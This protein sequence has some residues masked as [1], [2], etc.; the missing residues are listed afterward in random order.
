MVAINKT[1]K[2]NKKNLEKIKHIKKYRSLKSNISRKKKG[3]LYFRQSLRNKSTIN[4]NYVY[5]TMKQILSK[6]NYIYTHRD[7]LNMDAKTYNTL[8]SIKYKL[9]EKIRKIM[10]MLLEFMDDLKDSV[11][12][13]D[14]LPK[15]SIF[16]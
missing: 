14:I 6:I 16:K 11:E 8:I 4:I 15:S 3:G 13:I 5:R 7:N 12:P 10:H 9:E 2:I 1:R